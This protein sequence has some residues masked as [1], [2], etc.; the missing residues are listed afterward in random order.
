MTKL[1]VIQELRVLE[2]E[3]GRAER[4]ISGLENAVSTAGTG[5]SVHALGEMLNEAEVQ[6]TDILGEIEHWERVYDELEA[7]EDTNQV[8][9]H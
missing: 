9:E 6:R 7:G 3:L 4:R 1:E 5:Y 2:R 8:W